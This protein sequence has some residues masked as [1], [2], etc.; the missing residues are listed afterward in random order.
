MRINKFIASSGLC[1]RRKADELIQEKRV[2][3]NGNI[4]NDLSYQVQGSDVVKVDGKPL[5]DTNL[6]YVYYVLNKPVGYECTLDPNC[7]QKVTDL[8]PNNPPVIYVGRLDKASEGLLILTNDGSMSYKLTHPKFQ[9]E[10]EYEVTVDRNVTDFELDKLAKGVYI[11]SLR[12]KPCEVKRISLRK[13]SIVLTEGRNRQIRKMTRKL[14]LRVHKLK[15][16]RVG[17]LSIGDLLP[18]EYQRFEN[19]RDLVY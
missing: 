8:V 9:K 7:P 10:K 17:N 3:V 15:R 14:N 12:T 2:E 18:G 19:L 6:E 1:S 4:L 13:F 16:I 11:D 5:D